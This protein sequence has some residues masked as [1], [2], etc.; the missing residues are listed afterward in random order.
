MTMIPDPTDAVPGSAA[1]PMGSGDDWLDGLLAADARDERS[2]YIADEGFTARVMHALPAPLTLPAWRK[3]V[4]IGL[5]G[6]ALAGVSLALPGAVLDIAR[7]A[8]R[9]LGAH[10]VSLSGMAGA[11]VFAGALSWSVAA[12]TLRSSD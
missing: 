1:V 5:W 11:L 12:Y 6:V 8:Y 4:V 9:L 10:P 3:P 7:E 2:A